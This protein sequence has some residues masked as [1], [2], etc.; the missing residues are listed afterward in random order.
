MCFVWD[1]LNSGKTYFESSEL[2]FAKK[3]S[4]NWS[5]VFHLGRAPSRLGVEVLRT[6]AGEDGEEDDRKYVDDAEKGRCHS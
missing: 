6:R 3:A 1:I 2:F 4:I 5:G